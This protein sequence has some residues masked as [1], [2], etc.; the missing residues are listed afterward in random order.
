MS[1]IL[2]YSKDLAKELGMNN[3]MMNA[4]LRCHDSFTENPDYIVV[5]NPGSEKPK[6][7]FTECGKQ[8]FIEIKKTRLE[9]KT[10]PA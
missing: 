4:W 6:R 10:K 9:N 8:K 5:S 1:Q 2:Y 3:D 7:Y